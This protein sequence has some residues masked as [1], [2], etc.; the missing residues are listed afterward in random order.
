[1]RVFSKETLCAPADFEGVILELKLS[2]YYQNTGT[3]IPRIILT[4]KELLKIWFKRK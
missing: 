3:Y 1:L 2:C 4:I